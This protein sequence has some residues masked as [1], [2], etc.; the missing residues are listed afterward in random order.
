MAVAAVGTSTAKLNMSPSSKGL[1]WA[2][3]FLIQFRKH[4]GGKTWLHCP[5]LLWG[6]WTARWEERRKGD[7]RHS[8]CFAV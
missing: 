3:P 7:M 6:L 2:F 8:V 5:L 4:R 1:C